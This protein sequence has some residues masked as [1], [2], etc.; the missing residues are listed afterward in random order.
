MSETN[1]QSNPVA[2]GFAPQDVLLQMQQFSTQWLTSAREQLDRW[3]GAAE[4]LETWQR[5]GMERATEVTDE[6]A[7]LMRSGVEY[8]NK[9]F[10]QW[11]STGAEAARRSLELVT[12]KA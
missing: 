5:E 9:L 8:G 12:P 11:R 3:E 6:M 2:P 10:E 4:Q 7:K 1:T